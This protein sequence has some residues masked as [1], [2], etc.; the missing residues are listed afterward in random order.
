MPSSRSLLV[1]AMLLGATSAQAQHRHRDRHHRRHERR[2][3]D[4]HHHRDEAPPAA[5]PVTVTT[6]PPPEAPPPPPP[7]AV[8]SAAAPSMA[9]APEAPPP[10]PQTPPP[11]R[12]DPLWTPPYSTRPLTLPA[13]VIRADGAIGLDRPV[14]TL[15][16]GT[17]IAASTV[18]PWLRLGVGYGL[19]RAVE[20]GL[21]T[22]PLRIEAGARFQD[23]SLYGRVRLLGSERMDLGAQVA[24]GYRDGAGFASSY[25]VLL[26]WRFEAVRLDV[27]PSVDLYVGDV[28]S[29]DLRV[30]VDLWWRIADVFAIGLRTGVIAPGFSD[31]RLGILG[32]ARAVYSLAR[33]GRP[34]VDV[35]A[36]VDFEPL[37][38]LSGTLFRDDFVVGSVGAQA[39]FGP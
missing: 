34:F 9:Q 4:R 27:S 6:A 25:A 2:H 30:P 19:T 35:Y 37:I 8:A 14:T 10:V 17:R 32:G 11:P 7:V 36:A 24:L 23:I 16:G 12:A 15:A 20:V 13:R 29:A 22:A 38:H 26:R 21:S 33:D 1:V 3:R 31:G 5:T 39:H 28:T 18:A